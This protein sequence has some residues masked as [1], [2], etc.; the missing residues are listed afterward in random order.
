M[1]PDL[2]PPLRRLAVSIPDMLATTSAVISAVAAETSGRSDGGGRGQQK[3]QQAEEEEEEG[4]GLWRRAT[5][6]PAPSACPP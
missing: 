4:Q 6:T 5:G 2:N 3:Q 1:R